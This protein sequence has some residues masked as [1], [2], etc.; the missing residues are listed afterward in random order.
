MV[1]YGVLGYHAT[2]LAAACF[3]YP[4]AKKHDSR[5]NL[6]SRTTIQAPT[7]QE[8]S[9]SRTNDSR[10][11]QDRFTHQNDPIQVPKRADSC[12]KSCPLLHQKDLTFA[13]NQKCGL[14]F[15]VQGFGLWL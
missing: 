9:D 13:T 10:T 1:Q 14:G 7:I 2:D 12:T 4:F 11:T 5:T 8:L 6:D 3:G 15:W